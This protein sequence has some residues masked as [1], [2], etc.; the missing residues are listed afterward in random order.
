[1]NALA[2]IDRV[3]TGIHPSD[4][5]RREARARHEVRVV[6]HG[7]DVMTD[8]GIQRM[9][10]PLCG[11]LVARKDRFFCS[12]PSLGDVHGVRGFAAGDRIREPDDVGVCDGEHFVQGGQEVWVGWV[13]G[14]QGKHSVWQQVRVRLRKPAGL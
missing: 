2:V 1:V 8:S 12:S 13:V 9:P 5:A 6:E 7:A 14:P 4:Q 3:S 10:S 11:E